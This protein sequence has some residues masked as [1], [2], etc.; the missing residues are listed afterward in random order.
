[1]CSSFSQACAVSNLL[2]GCCIGSAAPPLLHASGQGSSSVAAGLLAQRAAGTSLSTVFQTCSACS[3]IGTHLLAESLTGKCLGGLTPLRWLD[4]AGLM[5]VLTSL[6]E[7]ADGQQQCSTERIAFALLTGGT[8]L[9][10]YCSCS[11]LVTSM[12][13]HHQRQQSCFNVSGGEETSRQNEEGKEALFK[14]LPVHKTDDLSQSWQSYHVFIH[15]RALC[16]MHSHAVS[17]E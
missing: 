2:P 5:L 9:K 1:M 7:H 6:Q 12:A 3:D 11:R 13:V 14:L 16:G 10:A 4:R 17:P 15:F 8:I